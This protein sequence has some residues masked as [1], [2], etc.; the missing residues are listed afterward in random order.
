MVTGR[1]SAGWLGV[2]D[3]FAESGLE[4]GY[5]NDECEALTHFENMVIQFM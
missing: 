5:L 2:F 4:L 3:H 1:F